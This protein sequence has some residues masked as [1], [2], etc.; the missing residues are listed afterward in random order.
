MS[1]GRLDMYKG[2]NNT[3]QDQGIGG[4]FL[5]PSCAYLVNTSA[6]GTVGASVSAFVPNAV[7]PAVQPLTGTPGGSLGG[8]LFDPTRTLFLYFRNS[9]ITS[10]TGWQPGSPE[11]WLNTLFYDPCEAGQT[12]TGAGGIYGPDGAPYIQGAGAAL[13][14]AA[15]VTPLATEVCTEVNNGDTAGSC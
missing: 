12:C 15:G 5:D 8:A 6:C 4:Y 9:D 1:Q 10:T 11:N 3:G 13:L 7:T 14:K 2:V